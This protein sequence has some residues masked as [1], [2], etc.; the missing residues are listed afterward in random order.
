M[1]EFYDRKNV[2]ARLERIKKIISK[3][4]W[5]RQTQKLYDKLDS[6]LLKGILWGKRMMSK[7]KGSRYDIPLN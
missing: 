4:K 2:V 3:N 7:N 6:D 5:N 1:W